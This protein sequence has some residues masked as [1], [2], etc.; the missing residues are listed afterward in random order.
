MKKTV[1]LLGLICISL[2]LFAA[3]KENMHTQGISGEYVI[4]RDYSWKEPTWVGFLYY[5]DDTYG[6][7]LYTP[8]TESRVCMLFNGQDKK[9]KF[10][11]NGQNIISKIT[12]SDTLAVNYLM[13]LLPSLYN[14]KKLPQPSARL[15]SRSA[16]KDTMHQFGGDIELQYATFV[17]LFH[18]EALKNSKGKTI[19][20]LV[21]MGKISQENDKS[22]FEF[23]EPAP[24]K[25]NTT[26]IPTINTKAKKQEFTV[27][28][29]KLQLDSQWSRL[30]ENS[31]LSSAAFITINTINESAFQSANEADSLIKLFALSGDAA[32]V[33]ISQMTATG[34]QNR[35]VITFPVFDTETQIIN[36]SIKTCIKNA[37][38]SY[39]IVSLTVNQ[40]IYQKYKKYFDT[41]L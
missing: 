39:T 14:R 29:I 10:I 12:P 32:K 15:V 7:M 34:S 21:Q 20:E 2:S 23:V 38:K 31:F 36:T 17:P 25:Q 6:A 13:D 16:K 33:L 28:T 22:F 4:Y 11:L 35:L 5:D 8:K 37:D 1:F 30:T 40:N 41:L 26:N 9:G 19:L 24:K 27:D 3:E 18:I